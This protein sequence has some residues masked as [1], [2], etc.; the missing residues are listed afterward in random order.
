M[1]GVVYYSWNIVNGDGYV[2]QHRQIDLESRKKAHFKSPYYFGNALRKYGMENFRWVILDTADSQEELNEKEVYWI[3]ILETICPKG[4]N[5]T[6]GG[7]GSREHLIG[8]KTPVPAWNKGIPA[9]EA[10]KLKQSQAMKGRI[11]WNKGLM[12][13]KYM[14]GN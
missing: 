9:S 1:W 12:L 7:S 8:I 6:L 10:Q 4:Y 13:T 11:P 14:Q 5:I 3:E 2:G